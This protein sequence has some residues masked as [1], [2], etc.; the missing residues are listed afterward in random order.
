MRH[1]IYW[2]VTSA[3]ALFIAGML[4]F[5]VLIFERPI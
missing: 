1:V 2:F 3:V 4:V 5:G